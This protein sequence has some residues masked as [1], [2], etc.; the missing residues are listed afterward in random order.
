MKSSTVKFV[1]SVILSSMLACAQAAP[2]LVRE[3]ADTVAS[4]IVSGQ[5]GAIY[6]EMSPKLKRAYSKDELIAPLALGR[7]MYGA[8][9]AYNFKVDLAQA[10]SRQVGDEWIRTVTYWY[11]IQTDRHP[12]GHWMKIDITQE[13]GHLYLAGYATVQFKDG[14]TP[15]FL[16]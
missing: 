2:D 1:V 13:D 12:N 8:I 10:G 9:T 14:Q 6:E 15:A 7:K 11:P 4:Q 16:K 3:M 5:A